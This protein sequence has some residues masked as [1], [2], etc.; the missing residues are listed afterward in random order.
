MRA[1]FPTF[2]LSESVGNGTEVLLQKLLRFLY[3][4]ATCNQFFKSK[5]FQLFVK[6]KFRLLYTD[7]GIV[8]RS[9]YIP[10]LVPFSSLIYLPAGTADS[11]FI[12]KVGLTSQHNLLKP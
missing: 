8:P 3:S 2:T 4:D 12:L 10:R 6:K 11:T 1:E 7:R 9:G 5:N